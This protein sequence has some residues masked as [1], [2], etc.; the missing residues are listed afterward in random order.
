MS[1]LGVFSLSH[2]VHPAN[3]T[4]ARLITTTSLTVHRADVGRGIFHTLPVLVM[5]MAG[6]VVIIMVHTFLTHV[7]I[8]MVR[9]VIGSTVASTRC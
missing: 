5:H 8:I 4:F 1:V 6:I 9:V 3:R 7:V 2:V